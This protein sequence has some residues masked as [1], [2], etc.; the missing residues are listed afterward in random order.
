MAVSVISGIPKQ[1]VH[2][3]ESQK[4]FSKAGWVVELGSCQEVIHPTNTHALLTVLAF[5]FLDQRL[6]ADVFVA[7][8]AVKPCPVEYKSSF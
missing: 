7:V 6:V 2:D 4:G 8:F 3:V 1:P 5:A